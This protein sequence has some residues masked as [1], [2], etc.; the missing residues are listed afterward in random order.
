MLGFI[1]HNNRRN[2]YSHSDTGYAY[3]KFIVEELKPF[4]DRAYR[5]LSDKENTAVCGSSLGG[6]I[7]FM[8]F[9]EYSDIFSKAACFSPA[10]KIDSI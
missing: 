2:E 9:W 10:F 1:I 5:T 6:L 3:M 7:S 4:I 8:I